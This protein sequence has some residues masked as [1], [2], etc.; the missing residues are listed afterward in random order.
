MFFYQ[1][2][3]PVITMLESR[4][5]ST[6][7]IPI[8]NGEGLQIVHYRPGGHYKCHWDYFAPDW[9]NSEKVLARGGQRVITFLMYLNTAPPNAGGETFFPLENL[10][11]QPVE[12]MALWWHNLTEDGQVDKST[13][14][15]A[16]PVVEGEKWIMTKWI[17]E[18]T[19]F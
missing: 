14:H 9:A 19:F 1:R 16:T 8:V 18:R 4:I 17:R 7:G 3:N 6:V 13:Y 15:E 11:F 5:A 10:A 2:E 12:G